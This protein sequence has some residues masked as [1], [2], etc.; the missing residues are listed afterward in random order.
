[1]AQEET[2]PITNE[3]ETKTF[4]QE[5]V[6]ALIK[7]RLARAKSEVPSDYEELKSKAQKFDELENANKTELQKANEEVEKLRAEVE[8]RE[9]VDAENALKQEI[10]K[11]TGVP[12]DLISG[13]D[14]DTMRAFAHRLQE[15]AKK[16]TAPVVSNAGTFSRGKETDGNPYRDIVRQLNRMKGQ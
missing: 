13:G 1:M 8:R 7:K 11:E 10:S 15:Y 6:D 3:E 16:D 12:V 5:E 14:E 9:K 4:T 2:Q